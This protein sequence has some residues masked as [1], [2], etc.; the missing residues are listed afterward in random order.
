[1]NDIRNKIDN[2]D[3]MA[4][5][6]AMQETD[7]NILNI[8]N[9]IF[10]VVKLQHE[11]IRDLQKRVDLLSKPSG[12]SEAL[13]ALHKDALPEGASKTGEGEDEV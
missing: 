1:M 4:N 5:L 9:E 13:K 8:V 12:P 11:L 3:L 2:D 7:E 6:G 10:T